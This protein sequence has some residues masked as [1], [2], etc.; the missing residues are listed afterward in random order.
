MEFVV[1]P[2]VSFRLHGMAPSL[3]A[4]RNVWHNIYDRN[5]YL[6]SYEITP[7]RHAGFLISAFIFD[8]KVKVQLFAYLNR[9]STSPETRNDEIIRT[10]L[11]QLLRRKPKQKKMIKKKMIM[12]IFNRYHFLKRHIFFQPISNSVYFFEKCVMLVAD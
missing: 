12:T 8:C 6:R 3:H 9:T 2:F 1:E 7:Q 5:T 10:N 11:N 4:D